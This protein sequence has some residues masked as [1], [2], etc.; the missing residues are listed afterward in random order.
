MNVFGSSRYRLVPFFVEG[1][2]T[3]KFCSSWSPPGPI[4]PM[5][6]HQNQ[7]RGHIAH[8][9]PI[10]WPVRTHLIDGC[11]K[12]TLFLGSGLTID[13]EYYAT[14]ACPLYIYSVLCHRCS[15]LQSIPG[16]L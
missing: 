5:M 14:F 1:S 12:L 2:N 9:H 13:P 15:A 7:Y 10:A 4:N 11:E 3:N 8:N 6:I 16:P